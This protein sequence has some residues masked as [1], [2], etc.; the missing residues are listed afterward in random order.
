MSTRPILTGIGVVA[1]ALGVLMV[2]QP[3]LATAISADYAAVLLI[4][5]LALVQGV[6]IAQSRRTSEIRG[7]ETPD[8]ETVETMPTPGAE[9]DERVARMRSGPRRTTIRERADLRD[10]LLDAAVSAVAHAENC[11]R[12]DA[13]ER[14]DAGTWTDDVHAAAFLGGDDAPNP[15]FRSKLRLAFSTESVHQFRLRRAADAVARV[16]GVESNDEVAMSA[17][18]DTTEVES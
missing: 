14:I 18:E 8:V 9:F 10:A 3:S 4:G 17:E 16:A 1:V 7:A 12:E 6:R 2:V 11:S 15:P 5:A 13:R